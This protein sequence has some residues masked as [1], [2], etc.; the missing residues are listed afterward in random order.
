MWAE[1]RSEWP[2]PILDD[3]DNGKTFDD[4]VERAWLRNLHGD[5]FL[6][7]QQLDRE[8]E[9]GVLF[10]RQGRELIWSQELKRGGR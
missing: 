5:G 6:Y 4:Y 10:N 1:A 2:L 8:E 3:Y 9:E 7:M